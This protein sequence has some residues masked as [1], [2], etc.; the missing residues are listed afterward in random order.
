MSRGIT[1]LPLLYRVVNGSIKS[2]TQ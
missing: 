2:I 1:K